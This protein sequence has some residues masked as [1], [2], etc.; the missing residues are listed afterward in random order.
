MTLQL[1]QEPSDSAYSVEFAMVPIEDI[2][3]LWNRCSE[4]LD[5]AFDFTAKLDNED[6]RELCLLGEAQLW[7]IWSN[8]LGQFLGSAITE[9]TIY[10][11][12]YK[13]LTFLAFGGSDALD[14]TRRFVDVIEQFGRAEGCDAVE[15]IGRKGWGKVF[16]DYEPTS[17]SYTKEL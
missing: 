14:W 16:P 10:T 7:V 2:P 15:M 6:A 8:D 9:M 11:N 17:W 4:F 1:V 5:P 3:D 13:V 12:E